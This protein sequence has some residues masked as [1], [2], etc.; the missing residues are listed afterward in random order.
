M[1]QVLNNREHNG[2]PDRDVVGRRAD[3]SRHQPRALFELDQHDH[4]RIL[5]R[6]NRRMVRD[7]EAMHDATPRRFDR[8]HLEA[9]TAGTHRRR[10]MLQAATA[11]AALDQQLVL[12]E[13]F[14]EEAVVVRDAR[15]RMLQL[16]DLAARVWLATR[17]L[18]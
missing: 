7:D 5:E 13:P 16:I 15:L 11:R 12:H 4:V 14:P 18:E 2:H 8:F 10:R 1:N 3:Q 6:R 17:E 9:M